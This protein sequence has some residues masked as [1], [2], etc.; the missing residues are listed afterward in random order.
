[1]TLLD[2]V[3]LAICALV[4]VIAAGLIAAALFGSQ[5]LLEWLS[6]PGFAFDGSLV[7]IILV[8]LAAYL[9]VLA[10]RWETKRYI[11]YARDLGSVRISAESVES[12]IVEAAGQI[13]GVE[14]VKASFTDVVNPKVTL[15]VTAYPDHN[16]GELSEEIQETVKAYVERTVGV[17]IQEIDVFVV[18]ISPRAD[19]EL[20]GIV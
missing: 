20:P 4:L 8:L 14:Q 10:A 2:R 19:T 9:V 1:M 7:A 6:S 17:V 5:V 13:A 11:V 12:L 18:G 16:L 3:F 15:K